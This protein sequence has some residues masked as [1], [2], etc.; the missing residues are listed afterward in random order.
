MTDLENEIL[1]AAGNR[2]AAEIDFEILSGMLCTLGW[3]KV[4]LNPMSMEDSYAVDEW[5]TTNIKGN[6]NNMGLV[7]IFENSAE[8][9]WFILRWLT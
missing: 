4:I 3:T 8:A 9:N 5:T 2:M 6:F 1:E 7:W